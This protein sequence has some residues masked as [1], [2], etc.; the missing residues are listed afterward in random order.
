MAVVP[1][2]PPRSGNEVKPLCYPKRCH[3]TNLLGPPRVYAHGGLH[4][5][6]VCSMIAK[7]LSQT[8]R[9]INGYQSS[10]DE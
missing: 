9:F 6:T 8:C 4:S 2:P 7:G 1:A 3:T 10:V 5:E